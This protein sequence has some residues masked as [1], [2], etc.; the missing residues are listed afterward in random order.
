ML[1]IRFSKFMVGKYGEN[2]RIIIMVGA[3]SI[4]ILSLTGI[5]YKKKYFG[6]L[7]S[8]SLVVPLAIITIG[9]YIDNLYFASFGFVLML[10]LIPVTIKILPKYKK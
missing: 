3:L 4:S 1:T 8:L 2:V 6:A 5:V 10:I 9:M 7:M